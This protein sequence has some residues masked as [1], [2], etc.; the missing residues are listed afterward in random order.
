MIR[1]GALSNLG[2]SLRRPNAP[3]RARGS[4]SATGRGQV[5]AARPEAPR[6]DR[7]GSERLLIDQRSTAAGEHLVELAGQLDRATNDRVG[8]VLAAAL[9]GPAERIVLDLS[10]LQVIDVWGLHP[11]LTAHLRAGDQLKQLVIIPG[12]QAVQRVLDS[13]H[14]PFDYAVPPWFS[15][16]CPGASESDGV[17]QGNS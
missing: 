14:A 8:E 13:I 5:R 12:S 17:P 6:D 15:T 2:F 1:R 16:R 10:R 7:L 11:I 3:A 4:R 9:E